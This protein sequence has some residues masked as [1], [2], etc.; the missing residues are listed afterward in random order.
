VRV[1][2]KEMDWAWPD[3]ADRLDRREFDVIIS[4]LTITD[5]RNE[6]FEFVQYLEVR[7]VY[8]CRAG[9]KLV[10][11]P[12]DL[13]DKI[14]SVQK[15]TTPEK[16]VGLELDQLQ[17]RRAEVLRRVGSTEPFDDVAGGRADVTLADEPV[18]N[19]YAKHDDRLVVTGFAG[20]LAAPD[21]IGIALRKQDKEL[22]DAVSQ[23]VDRLKKDNGDFKKLYKL[24]F[25]P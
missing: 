12:R 6:R 7:T 1:E 5:E 19:W 21:R 18:A 8:V 3:V 25:S 16:E 23:A 13:A 15:N 4:G 17:G 20:G 2:F 22:K 14:I 10:H 9:G 24:L 11:A